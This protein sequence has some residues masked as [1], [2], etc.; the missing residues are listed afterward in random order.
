M[1]WILSATSKPVLGE[2][3][4][5]DVVESFDL[6]ADSF[7]Q[8]QSPGPCLRLSADVRDVLRIIQRGIIRT[9]AANHMKIII[10][11]FF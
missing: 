9:S 7:Q 6:Q 3:K 1:S 8:T 10:V 2:G 11:S 5:I 4:V